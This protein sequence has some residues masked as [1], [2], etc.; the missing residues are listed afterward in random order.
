MVRKHI[1]VK[2]RNKRF[3]ERVKT[4]IWHEEP[5]SKN[6]YLAKSCRCHGYDLL[7]LMRRRSFVDVLY[8]LFRGELPNIDE[9]R[10]LERLMIA[11]INLGP[12][13]PATRAAM[14]V[15][16]AKTDPCHILPISLAILGGEYLGAGQV[17]KAMQFLIEHQKDEVCSLVTALLNSGIEREKDCDCDI[18]PGFGCRFGDI[19]P[20]PQQIVN[21]L[22][23]LPAVG[24]YL[25]WGH[26]FAELLHASGM[27]W[28]NTG[29]VAATLLDLGFDIKAGAGMYQFLSAPGLLAHGVELV[30]KSI[31]A[32]PFLTDEQY[33]IEGD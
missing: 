24:R 11:S 6:A 29:V 4:E 28:L 8:L 27:G 14:N 2:S 9:A 10:I 26:E 19:D 7:D 31:M 30:D 15:A 20:L 5:D 18:A 22:L 33:V 21:E 32:M 23:N 12:R 13:H 25:L 3:A 16:V 1:K 17:V